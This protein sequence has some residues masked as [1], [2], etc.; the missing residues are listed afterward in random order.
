MTFAF[1]S[2]SRHCGCWRFAKYNKTANRYLLVQLGVTAG[3]I[4]H[5]CLRRGTFLPLS[6]K[7]PKEVGSGG[8]VEF[9]APARKAT[10][11]LRT[12]TRHAVGMVL[13]W[14]ELYKKG[15]LHRTHAIKTWYIATGFL[16]RNEEIPM[17][18]SRQSALFAPWSDPDPENA[19]PLLQG[20]TPGS[21]CRRPSVR[22]RSGGCSAPASPGP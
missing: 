22:R 16:I 3:N 20:P 15:L 18:F 14:I 7:V 10:L 9:I 12:P 13:W 2:W 5:G 6:K 17:R 4:R 1:R 11:P 19:E 21:R 8:G